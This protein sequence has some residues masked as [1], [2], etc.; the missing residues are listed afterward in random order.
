MNPK[1]WENPTDARKQR[2]SHFL[3]ILRENIAES[4]ACTQAQI[5]ADTVSRWKHD[6]P[7]FMA[8]Y[9]RATD[10]RMRNLEEGMWSALD[11]MLQPERYSQLVRYPSLLQFALRGGMPHKYA[12]RLVGQFNTGKQD[13]LRNLVG[14][15]GTVPEP[16]K[17]DLPKLGP[18]DKSTPSTAEWLQKLENSLLG[19]S[20]RISE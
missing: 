4:E 11:W 14:L 13:E 2:Q 1:E 19:E 8:E 17:V 3:E 12:E 7:D 20:D 16:G 10:N 6:D 15:D 5:T 18:Q 9:E